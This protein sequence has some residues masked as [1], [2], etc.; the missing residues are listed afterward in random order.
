M[1]CQ[2]VFLITDLIRR[3]S[4]PGETDRAWRTPFAIILSCAAGVVLAAFLYVPLLSSMVKNRYLRPITNFNP[5]VLFEMMPEIMR[6]FLSGRWALLLA[7]PFGIAALALNCRL[8]LGSIFK[9][10]K[11]ISLVVMAGIWAYC[12]TQFVTEVARKDRFLLEKAN[13]PTVERKWDTLYGAYYQAG[14]RPREIVRLTGDFL[15]RHRAPLPVFLAGELDEAVLPP[16]FLVGAGIDYQDLRR[17]MPR[18]YPAFDEALFL[19]TH[20]RRFDAF[21]KQELP[22]TI[23]LMANAEAMLANLYYCRRP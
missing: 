6:Y 5:E 23:C 10:R 8:A 21:V 16:D 13:S 17:T 15:A 22:G 9:G 7:V 2:G 12:S 20:P 3:R 18:D 4:S 19:V 11:A 14:Y 1:A